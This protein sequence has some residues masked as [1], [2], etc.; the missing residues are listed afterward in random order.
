MEQSFSFSEPDVFHQQH[1]KKYGD[2]FPR[3][4]GRI[5]RSHSPTPPATG[6]PARISL[7]ALPMPEKVVVLMKQLQDAVKSDYPES[8]L[9]YMTTSVLLEA[10]SQFYTYNHT[11]IRSKAS[12][13]EQVRFACIEGFR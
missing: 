13:C 9:D 11:L 5:A 4:R 7:P 2:V 6:S 12:L 10:F 3:Y 8:A 1:R